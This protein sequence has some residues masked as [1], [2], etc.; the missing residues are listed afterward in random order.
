M[1]QI[2]IYFVIKSFNLFFTYKYCGVY[3]FKKINDMIHDNDS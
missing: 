2:E 3:F 1:K